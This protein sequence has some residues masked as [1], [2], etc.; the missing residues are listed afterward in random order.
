MSRRVVLVAALLALVLPGAALAGKRPGNDNFSAAAGLSGSSGRVAASNTGATREAGEPS[1]AG[2][3]ASHSIWFAWTPAAS[4]TATIDTVGSSF[5]TVLAVYTGTRVDALTGVAENDDIV[6]GQQQQSRVSFAAAAGTTYRIAVDGWGGATGSVALGW[7]LAASTADT[8]PPDTTITSGPS[9]TVTSTSASFSFA[10]SEPASFACSLDGAAFVACSAPAA[11]S[12]LAAGSHSFQVRATDAAG[13]VDPTPASATWTVSP[14]SSGPANDAFS[15]AQWLSGASGQASGSNVGAT[16]EAGEPSH[17]LDAG[18]HSVWYRWTAPADGTLAVDLAGSSFDTLLAVYTGSAVDALALLTSNDDAY[19]GLQQSRLAFA[20]RAGQTYSIAVDG[21]GGAT[22]TIAL[23]WSQAAPPAP[24]ASGDPVLVAAGDQHAC[25]GPGASATADVVDG[26]GASVVATLGDASGPNG[27]NWEYR[28]CLDPSWGRFLPRIRPA[29]GNHDVAADTTG[30]AYYA[31]FG[32]AAGAKGQG[33]YSYD[34]GSWHV[35]VLNSD[36]YELSGGC[37]ATSPQVAWLKQDLA[38]HPAVC[39]LAY[40]HHPLFTSTPYPT[41]GSPL[42]LYKALYAA[43]ADVVLN[44]HSHTYERFAPQDPAGAIDPARGLREFVVGTGGTLLPDG[45][46]H[47]ANSEVW[48][49]TTRGVL[50]L[51]LHAGGYDW[52]FV[53]VA[54]ASFTDSG[55]GACH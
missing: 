31:Y 30:A 45:N 17:A 44:A 40:W 13:N 33:W 52:R 4:G 36:C 55:S 39:T 10:A 29:I 14:A 2:S 50:Q 37:G 47:A 22:G 8:T 6:S 20:A 42:E 26:L 35:V 49:N 15:S 9:G 12:G 28:E 46:G 16:K 27:S 19:T 34:L 7:S 18:G 53:P 21:W 54:G 1:H 38:A 25:E 51:T 43:G 23:A 11:Y 3:P 24:P 5:D 48:Q 32:A 41:E